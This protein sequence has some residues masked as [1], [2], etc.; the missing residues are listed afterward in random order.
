MRG[1]TDFFL[2]CFLIIYQNRVIIAPLIQ[3]FSSPRRSLGKTNEEGTCCW[4][5]SISDGFAEKAGV[6]AQTTGSGCTQFKVN[7]RLK[8]HHW[9][10]EAA[11]WYDDDFRARK[12]APAES[13]K[14]GRE[15]LKDRTVDVFSEAEP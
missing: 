4:D 14:S 12:R 9:R 2:T 6:V 5:S 10:A 15:L 11:K 7:P 8:A 1:I 3:I 13:G